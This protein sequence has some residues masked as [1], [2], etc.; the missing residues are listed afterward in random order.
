MFRLMPWPR[1]FATSSREC[2]MLS[3]VQ[4]AGQGSP[5]GSGRDE[6]STGAAVRDMF[7]G[8]APRYDFLNHFLSLGRDIAWRRAAAR[9]LKDVLERPGS[10]V[11]DLCCGTGD[12]SFSFGRHSRGLVLGADFCPPMLAIA[13]AKAG[14][15]RGQVRFLAADALHLPFGDGTLDAVASAF[16]F[17]NLAS[18]TQGMGEMRRVLKPGGRVAILEFSQ[19]RWPIFGPLFRFYF[20][21]ILPPLGAWISGVQGPYRYLPESVARFPNQEALAE[22]LRKTGFQKVTYRNFT[23]GVA[24]LHVG[25]R[26]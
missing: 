25:E 9:A 22:Q 6:A 1:L 24:A 18:Y 19:V 11:A 13:R 26:I 4:A 21:R 17:R 5:L 8:V 20:R 16:G 23:G 12:L 10:C 14:A 15:H 7:A 3:A 2:L